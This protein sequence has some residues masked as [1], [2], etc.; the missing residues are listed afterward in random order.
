MELLN[1]TR[2][3]NVISI[4]ENPNYPRAAMRYR[5]FIFM[6]KLLLKGWKIWNYPQEG[7]LEI[8]NLDK[9]YLSQTELSVQVLGQVSLGWTWDC[10]T[11]YW[12]PVN[13]LAGANK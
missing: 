2:E 5:D 11:A 12:K 1:S 6:M 13:L 9:K 7:E 10:L 8:T 3:Y 4:E